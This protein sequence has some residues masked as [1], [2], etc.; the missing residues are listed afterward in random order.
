M[1]PGR[2][3]VSAALSTATCKSPDQATGPARSA[4]LVCA[5]LGAP[6]CSFSH[7]RQ[8]DGLELEARTYFIPFDRCCPGIKSL[9]F[10]CIEPLVNCL[11]QVIGL[12]RMALFTDIPQT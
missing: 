12:T 1:N 8:P 4:T 6:R 2:L 3:A 9:L 10:P 11:L 7:S 5:S